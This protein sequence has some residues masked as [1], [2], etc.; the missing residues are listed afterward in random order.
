MANGIKVWNANG[1]VQFDTAGR[2]FRKLGEINYGN[3]NGSAGFSRQPEDTRVVPV[4]LGRYPP[5]FTVNLSNNT[6]SWDQGALPAQY[7]FGGIV[8][9]WAS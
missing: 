1:S 9:L 6:I 3:T 4:A 8:E 5:P 2:L 7:R